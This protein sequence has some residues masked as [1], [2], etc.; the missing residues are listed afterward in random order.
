MEVNKSKVCGCECYKNRG[1]T[2]CDEWI[3]DCAAFC[4]FANENGYRPGLQIDRIYNN[5]GYSPDN[6]RFVDVFVNANN[7]KTIRA[8]N[9]TGFRGVCGVKDKFSATI[10]F[11]KT[12]K[13]QFYGFKTAIEAAIFRDNYC[14][15][16]NIKTTLNFNE[17]ECEHDHP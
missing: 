12:G 2:V 6:C 14:K 3:N 1:I 7:K 4:R 13:L 11:K 10:N 8:D 5:K 17:T 9:K 16:N 15:S